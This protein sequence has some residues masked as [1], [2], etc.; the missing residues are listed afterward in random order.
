RHPAFSLPGQLWAVNGFHC[1]QVVV[2]GVD[3]PAD[4]SL[5][6]YQLQ[7]T[8]AVFAQEK[9]AVTK[10]RGPDIHPFAVSIN[11]MADGR[12]IKHGQFS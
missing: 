4:T 2:Q 7:R 9:I 12:L 1:R 8:A 5:I 6:G 11:G 10:P 3:E